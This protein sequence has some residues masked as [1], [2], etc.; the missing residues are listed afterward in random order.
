MQKQRTPEEHGIAWTMEYTTDPKTRLK[1][2][3]SIPTNDI[4][5]SLLFDNGYS[6]IVVCVSF[7]TYTT[8]V[9]GR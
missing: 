5:L 7:D 8:K 2:E 3:A 1:I 4:I 6:N 9:V